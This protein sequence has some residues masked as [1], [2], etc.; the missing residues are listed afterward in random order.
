[1]G[2]EEGEGGGVRG[3]EVEGERESRW[4]MKVWQLPEDRTLFKYLYT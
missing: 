2:V 3:E 4:T 1:M